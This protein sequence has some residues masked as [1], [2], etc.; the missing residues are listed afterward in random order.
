MDWKKKLMVCA[1]VAA[2]TFTAI[3]MPDSAAGQAEGEQETQS[4]EEILEVQAPQNTGEFT[5]KDGV[6]TKCTH[7]GEGG[8]VVIPDGVTTIGQEAFD[9]YGVYDN[10][11]SVTIPGSVKVIEEWA[12]DNC[13]KLTS[14]TFSEGLETIGNWAFDN[15]SALTSITLPDSVTTLNGA[16]FANC[17]GLTSI[18]IPAGVTSVQGSSFFGCSGLTSIT[19]AEG[20]PVY[21]S[22]NCNAVIET[23]SN[24]LVLGCK[25]TIIPDGITAIEGSAFRGHT[26][27]ETIAIPASVT[28]IGG[29]AFYECSGLT[30]L[31]IPDGVTAIN[32][33]TFGHCTSLTS[34][35]IPD[36]VTEIGIFA[37]QD[38][39]ALKSAVIPASVTTIGQWAFDNCSSELVIYG[40]A[41][42]RA[43]SYAESNGIT[44]KE[45]SDAPSVDTPSTDTP[46]GVE[47]YVLDLSNGGAVVS[48]ESFGVVLQEN[49][50][51][52]VVIKTE[53]NVTFTFKAGTMK[54]VDGKDSYDFT[55]T[56]VRE[57]DKITGLPSQVTGSN[58]VQKVDYSYS[59]ALPAEASIRMYV[60]RDHAGQT[61]YY[62]HLLSDNSISLMQAATVDADG[63]ITVKQSHCSSYIVTS[64]DLKT[65]TEPAASQSKDTVLPKTGD[66]AMPWLYTV[67]TISAVGLMLVAG[68]RAVRNS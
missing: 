23:A 43:Q 26:G 67:L 27:L 41:G 14:V 18:T 42:S 39:T 55:V 16:A 40:K 60:G 59:G 13:T 25:T 28:S 56:I 6:L 52:D 2:L 24:T 15:C 38:C 62:S 7:V 66:E 61:L 30:S 37:F 19:V 20:N 57:F 10:L 5:I 68:R 35:S 63:Y 51:K 53:N 12:F 36:S 47:S 33:S 21:D 50:T 49:Q 4:T 58:F 29:G 32:A 11:T 1:A 8:V 45:M 31:T 34:I 46:V 48:K 54:E 64:T 65:V 3:P 9:G 22:R 44:F 17:T